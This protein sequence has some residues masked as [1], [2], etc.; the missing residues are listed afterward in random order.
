MATKKVI[1]FHLDSPESPMVL[2]IAKYLYC[3]LTSK[4]IVDLNWIL[5]RII[6]FFFILPIRPFIIQKYY[7]RIWDKNEQKFLSKIYFERFFKKLRDRL[8]QS[9]IDVEVVYMPNGKEMIDI[10]NRFS[11]EDECLLLP[12]FPQYSSSTSALA[13]D[14]FYKEMSKRA[15]I[16]KF[17][18][19]HSLIVKFAEASAKHIVEFLKFNSTSCGGTCSRLIVL[20]FHGMPKK[21]IYN[22][23]DPYLQ[24]CVYTKKLIQEQLSMML[25]EIVHVEMA[26]HSKFGKGEW[27]TP[28][29]RDVISI[30]KSD[31]FDDAYNNS[32]IYVY[33]PSFFIDSLETIDELGYRLPQELKLKNNSEY[34]FI[35]CMNDSKFLVESLAVDIENTLAS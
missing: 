33:S 1:I 12:L 9:F 8:S 17:Y 11:N 5:W 6:L 23:N 13:L 34:F 10:W 2:D 7:L 32:V 24:E 4:R 26:F 20:S 15:L 16:P 31:N 22:D 35:P 28:D 19:G 27:L 3:F 14:L 25:N 21:R 30:I 18:F 29:I